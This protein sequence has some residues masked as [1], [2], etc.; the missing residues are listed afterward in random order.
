MTRMGRTFVFAVTA[1]A[2]A[3]LAPVRGEETPFWPEFH[4]PRR[5]NMSPDKGLLREWPAGGP[6]LLWKAPGC[7]RGYASVSIADGMVFTSGDIGPE[8]MVIALDLEGKVRWKSANGLAWRGPQP[9]SRTTPTWHDGAVYHLNAHGILSAFESRTGRR[10][11]SVNVAQ[12]FEAR[13]GGWG[14]AEN[15]VV[16]DNLV[17]CTPGGAR[18]RVVAL[19]RKTGATVWANT[20]MTDRAAYGSPIVVSHG[21]RRV[22]INFMHATVVGVEVQTGKLLWSHRH[23]STCDQNVTRPLYHDGHVFVTSG[24]RGGGRWLR[25]DGAGTNVR[26]LWFDRDFDNCHGGVV[27]L[28]GHLYFCGC[29]MYNKG[30]ICVDVSTGRRLYRA[31]EIGKVSITWAEGMLYC[32]DND[33]DV[34]LVRPAP[35]GAR[36]VSRFALPREDKENTLAHPVVCGGRLYLRHLDNLYVYDVAAR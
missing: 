35:E 12:R 21:G 29:R 5:D 27:L 2:V 28:D 9:G 4:G 13:P 25:L 24:H 14:Y 6:K 31:E 23:P 18:G 16:E 20:E 26:E 1:A 30:L 11:W 7:G 32:L 3:T 17:L 15:V 36:V 10:L 33:G 8:Q 22:L 34:L 19:D